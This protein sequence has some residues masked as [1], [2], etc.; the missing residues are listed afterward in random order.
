MKGR[1]VVWVLTLM[2][3]AKRDVLVDICGLLGA[4]HSASAGPSYDG[5]TVTQTATSRL[6]RLQLRLP[7][8]IRMRIITWLA[9]LFHAVSNADAHIMHTH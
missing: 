3:E 5:V 4:S 2:L 1:L 9:V 7:Y 8:C 6:L